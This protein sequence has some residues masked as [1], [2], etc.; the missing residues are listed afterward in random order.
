ML[1]QPGCMGAGPRDDRWRVAQHDVGA[2][3]VVEQE[4]G[5]LHQA[6]SALDTHIFAQL[7]PGEEPRERIKNYSWMVYCRIR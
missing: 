3:R 1:E 5:R 6:V 2:V 4:E 7:G